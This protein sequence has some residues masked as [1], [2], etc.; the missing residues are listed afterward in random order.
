MNALVAVAPPVPDPDSAFYWQ[1]LREH[2]LRVQQCRACDRR[3]FPPMPNCPYCASPASEIR[4]ASGSGTVYSWVV[5]HRAFDPAFAKDV[6][7]VL[8]TVDLDGGGRTVGRLEG[9]ETVDFGQRVAAVFT[10]HADW[11]EL[12]FRPLKD[13]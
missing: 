6:P 8:A 1:G 3:R 12:R 4:Q 5:V 13:D 10:D 2:A 11:T 7:Y 9:T